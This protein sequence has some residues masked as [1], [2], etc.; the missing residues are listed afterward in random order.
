MG[1]EA[2]TMASLTERQKKAKAYLTSIL[3][4]ALGVQATGNGFGTFVT[5]DRLSAWNVSLRH[6][7]YTYIRERFLSVHALYI[8]MTRVE[9]ALK[10]QDCVMLSITRPAILTKAGC[11][12]SGAKLGFPELAQSDDAT[13][14]VECPVGVHHEVSAVMAA[15][16]ILSLKYKRRMHAK[17]FIDNLVAMMAD[18]KK[19]DEPHLAFHP[20]HLANLFGTKYAAE[21]AQMANGGDNDIAWEPSVLESPKLPWANNPDEV[22]R[23]CTEVAEAPFSMYI[24]DGC[25]AAFAKTCQESV[26]QLPALVAKEFISAKQAGQEGGGASEDAAPKK[27]R[28]RNEEDDEEDDGEL[29]ECPRLAKLIAMAKDSED[30]QDSEDSAV[31][32]GDDGGGISSGTFAGIFRIFGKACLDVAALIERNDKG[33]AE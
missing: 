26:E 22:K 29:K 12:C 21:L 17:F 25:K 13:S 3:Q 10:E 16:L 24:D 7:I 30:S 23:V 31:A 28:K 6:L 14:S 11:L 2:T 33:S 18:V 1:I 8:T 9:R 5:E 19:S 27:K 4:A 20:C 15:A 32:E